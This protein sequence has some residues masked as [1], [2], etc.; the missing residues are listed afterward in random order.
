[1][2][3]KLNSFD[4]QAAYQEVLDL[5]KT[6]DGKSVEVQ[7]RINGMA[8]AAFHTPRPPT[9]DGSAIRFIERQAYID[10]YAGDDRVGK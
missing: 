7:G 8:D 6:P 4:V 5:R 1:M 2:A 3:E 9:F 10:G